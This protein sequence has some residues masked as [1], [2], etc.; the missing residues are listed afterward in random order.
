MRYLVYNHP[1]G[2]PE[3]VMIPALHEIDVESRQVMP[4]VPFPVEDRE[5]EYLL[6]RRK[7]VCIREYFP[8]EGEQL[9]TLS[10][11]E[12]IDAQLAAFVA[13]APPPVEQEPTFVGDAEWH[14][15][16]AEEFDH[17]DAEEELN[18]DV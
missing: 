18:H 7:N 5:A 2:C 11:N 13:P 9:Q 1:D 6:E 17:I 14:A 15:P 8:K 4:G 10:S 12:R 3:P 16:A